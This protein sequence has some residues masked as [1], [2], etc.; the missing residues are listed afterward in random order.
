LHRVHHG[1]DVNAFV[2]RVSKAQTVHSVP[3]SGIE[4]LGNTFL[5]QQA[6]S[7]AADLPLIEP[8]R[9]D[10]PFDSR[11]NI[12]I[13]EHDIG[14]LAAQLERQ[15]LAAAGGCLADAP[16][17]RGRTGKGDLV[18]LCVNDHLAH[19]AVAGDDIDHTFGQPRLIADV[20]EQ[21]RGQRCVFGRFQHHGVARGQR[22]GDLPGQHQKREIPRDDLAT[23]P[24]RLCIRQHIRHQLRHA[25]VIIEMPLRQR[26]VDVAR[27]ADRFAIV[28]RFQHREQPAVF[29][30][31]PGDGIK[32]PRPA[33]PANAFPFALRRAGG[34]NSGVNL[35]LRGL[36]QGRQYLAGGRIAAVEP[37]AGRGERA[38]DEMPEPVALIHQPCQRLGGVF[39]GGA[40]FHAFEFVFDGHLANLHNLRQK[41]A[42][43]TQHK[44]LARF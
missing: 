43:Q 15:R 31:K 10:Q 39:R 14:R 17:Y 6:R 24:K 37:V 22:R 8:D 41:N 30:Q 38:V 21:Q 40:V 42:T 25:C 11:V 19:R 29:L 12:G 23:N 26:N 4:I 20:G 5:H 7:G 34:V 28:Q 9:I 1:T 16:T 3:Q 32:I 33:R 13:V 36:R 27:F 44:K 2:Q 35:T 18:Y